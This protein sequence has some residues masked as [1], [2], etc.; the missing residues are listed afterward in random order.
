MKKNLSLIVFMV[1]VCAAFAQQ[2]AITETGDEVVLHDNGTWEYVNQDDLDDE[3]PISNKKF[4]KP[5]NA[6]FQLKSK[7]FNVGFWLDPKKWTFTKGVD[8]ADA[9]YELELKEEDLYGMIITE[10][11]EIPLTTLKTIALENARQV[12][13]DIRI[14]DQEYRTVNGLKVLFL[15]MEGTMEGIKFSYYGYYYSNP[16]GTVQYVL[17][18]SQGLM[19]TYRNECGELLN[20]LSETK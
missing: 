10:K 6:T 17:Y 13:P 1:L 16:K 11:I 12:S 5:D 14:V 9:E 3:I 7:R 19:D 2:K 8:N 18:T 4:R 20:G 15:N